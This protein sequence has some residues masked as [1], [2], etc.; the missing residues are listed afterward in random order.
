M[1]AHDGVRPHDEQGAPPVPP[2]LGEQDPEDSIALAKLRAFCG[3]CQRSHL[4]TEREVLKR[5]RS[6][7]AA[8]Q[9]DRAE[10]YDQRRQHAL[11]CR[12]F[13]LKINRRTGRSG[14]GEG[15]DLGHT[16]SAHAGLSC[17]GWGR[18]LR[19]GDTEQYEANRRCIDVQI[20]RD[21]EAGLERRNRCYRVV[22]GVVL[23]HCTFLN[24]LPD[25]RLR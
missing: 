11:S 19:P 20:D 13:E 9:S 24:L 4:L 2:R 21:D 22:D 7:S 16:H 23:S 10:S 3:A 12:R 15:Q 18:D 8:D 6:V 1:P 5:D 14:I 17:S 25:S